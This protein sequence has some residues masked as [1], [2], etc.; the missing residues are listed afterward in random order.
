MLATCNVVYSGLLP[1]TASVF[2]SSE[3]TGSSVK[4]PELELQM[5]ERMNDAAKQEKT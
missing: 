2:R 5:L 4:E 3:S 1:V